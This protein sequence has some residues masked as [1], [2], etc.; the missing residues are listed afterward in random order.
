[1]MQR[2]IIFSSTIVSTYLAISLPVF[3]QIIP[4]QTANTSISGNCQTDCKINGGTRSGQNLFHSFEEF[5]LSKGSSA[6]FADPGVANIFSRV[7]GNNPSAIFG[8]LG[9]MGGDANLF[10]L[11]PNGIMFGEGATLDLNG[12]FFATTA[13]QIQFGEHVFAAIPNAQ[14]NLA[15]LTLNP[16]ALFFK[17]MGQN[18][19]IVLEGADLTVS[20]GKNLTL[21]GQ[22]DYTHSSASPSGTLKDSLRDRNPGILMKNSYLTVSNG[23]IN[24]GSVGKLDHNTEIALQKDF[25]LGFPG[26]T[27]RGNISITD[28]SQIYSINDANYADK[29]KQENS[30]II[31]PSNRPVVK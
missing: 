14:E 2:L 22:G 26:N 29:D 4:D 3:S 8:T 16:S 10:L 27:P 25:Q 19:S 17:Q 24:L 1:M 15:L 13:D 6:Y 28:S 9:V 31:F 5:N 21:L 11:N 18:G 23:N 12:S 30:E 20:E 7:T